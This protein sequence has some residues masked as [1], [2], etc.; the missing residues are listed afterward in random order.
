MLHSEIIVLCWTAASI[1]FVH[2]ALGPDHYLPFVMM[3]SV[4]KWTRTKTAWITFWC[5]VGHVMSSVVIG[6]VGIFIG[7]ELVHLNFIETYR[8]TWA[9]WGLI[10]FGLVYAIWGLR[11]AYKH[12]PHKH[13]HSHQGGVVHSHV[14][15]HAGDHAHA[16][17]A[18]V[19]DITPWV[20]FTIFVL[21]PCEPLIP[22]IM[23]P[24]SKNSVVGFVFVVIIFA[25]VTIATMLTIVLFATW[26]IS[27]TRLGKL[28]RYTHALAGAA[29]CLSGL[30]IVFL[31]L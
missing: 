28:E 3:A 25:V 7:A 16:H 14:H 29:I 12:K 17:E 9:A 24:A 2:T 19:K 1:A 21:G 11:R 31:G 13:L 26:G 23:Y 27:F 8:G 6:L 4:R 20:L 18:K 15:V 10:A 5:G 30:A 22:I